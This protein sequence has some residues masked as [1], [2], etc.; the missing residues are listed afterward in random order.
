M[1]ISKKRCSHVVFLASPE[2]GPRPL[3]TEAEIEAGSEAFTNNNIVKN[4]TEEKDGEGEDVKGEKE[5]ISEDPIDDE[6]QTC[7]S[8]KSQ[9][10]AFYKV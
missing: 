7:L 2:P 8:E 1:Q 4:E 5:D 10:N 3:K 9:W 6:H